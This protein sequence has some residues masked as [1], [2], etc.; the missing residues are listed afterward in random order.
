MAVNV[1]SPVFKFASVRNPKPMEPATDIIS[2]MPD[3]TLIQNIVAINESN[4]TN[5]QKLSD[6]NTL[7]QNYINSADFIKTTSSFYSTVDINNPTQA[8]LELMYD[9]LIVR[10]LT[11]SNT[12]EVYG[13]LLKYIKKFAASLN[14]TTENKI[15]IVIPEKITF[16]FT[17]FEGEN[18]YTPPTDESPTI[19]GNII[20]YT[21]VKNK[22][23]EAKENNI[24]GIAPNNKVSKRNT[25]FLPLLQ[26][27]G[28]SK[29][30]ISDAN[31]FINN[32]IT[33]L[34]SRSETEHLFPQTDEVLSGNT[35]LR[36][37]EDSNEVKVFNEA[38]H[39][40]QLKKLIQ[41][42]IDQNLTEINDKF[43][44]D[45]KDDFFTKKIHTK[46]IGDLLLK[47]K[48]DG[49]KIG[50]RR[51][52]K[53]GS[54]K[55]LEFTLHILSN[56]TF[57]QFNKITGI[58]F[59]M[60]VSNFTSGFPLYFGH[61]W[62]PD[63]RIMEAVAASM[64]I[65][66]AIKPLYNASDVVKSETTGRQLSVQTNEGSV[67]FVNS[68]GSFEL[69]DYYFYEHIVKRALAQEIKSD[70]KTKGIEININNSVDLSA[71]L[72]KLQELVVGKVNMETKEF[73]SANKNKKTELIN[74]IN[75]VNYTVDYDLYKFF[76]NAAYKGLLIDG[77]YRNNIP[78]NFFRL[79]NDN[80]D[81][82]L[83]I[84]LDEHFPP[85]LMADVY[86][87]IKNKLNKVETTEIIN[88]ID[89]SELDIP[90]IESGAISEILNN[91][92][93]ITY[94]TT[95]A[96]II[97]QTELVF[98]KYLDAWIER[99][100]TEQEKTDRKEI[101]RNGF[102]NRKGE[103]AIRRLVRSTLKHQR[104]KHLTPP[105]AQPKSIL[106]TA[107]EG[108]EYGSEKGQVK[109]ISDHN[110][111]LPL[112]DYG[113]GTYDFKMDKVMPQILLAQAQAEQATLD[114]FNKP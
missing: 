79:R 107:F 33:E 59:G 9:N 35:S 18:N 3:T 61:E 32:K 82:V 62:T 111:I 88:D 92:K 21:E 34:N 17:E 26:Y 5:A 57:K 42:A 86:N 50:E 91:A 27:F 30:I 103:K 101:V 78:Y 52:S 14:S 114:F 98:A 53:I 93:T 1:L 90:E 44:G 105:W 72:P 65:P 11:K 104:K 46:G 77:G 40:V 38:E 81:T 100:E 20:K 63:F 48:D 8:G 84:K 71:F 112:Y 95:K 85:D 87:A 68:D 99:G 55:D 94:K 13:L 64:T 19:I 66:P 15:R 43:G 76:Y 25:T 106:A 24:V 12:N 60:C 2:V 96:D 113:V 74:S 22:I 36:T 16:P 67:P 10:L 83:A 75:G 39:I 4:S 23:N 28:K 56:L 45:F 69:T 70:E 7:L 108:Y 6:T 31:T 51:A 41:L 49:F 58:N 97:T 89:L 110:Q 29:V 47:Y 109:E 54:D 102:R 80:I 37:T 73:E